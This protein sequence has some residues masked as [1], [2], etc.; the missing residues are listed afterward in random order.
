MIDE[1]YIKF[2]SRWRKTGCLENAEIESLN[3]WRRPLYD[4]GLIGYDE[5]HRIGYGNLSVRA[6]RDGFFIISGS[7]TGHLRQLGAEHYALVERCEIGK[8]RVYSS[9]ACEASSESLTHAAIYGLDSRIGAVV[10]VHC[11]ELWSRLRGTVA[12]TD[13]GVGFGTPVMAQEFVRLWNETDFAR[14]GIAV[15]AGHESGLISFGDDLEQ[16]AVR[17]L[18]SIE[19][20]TPRNFLPGSVRD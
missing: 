20:V 9:G 11:A 8:N 17:I 2:E 14:I 1:G 6:G 5:K 13:A 7:Q 3:R 4:A 16:A 12:T 19:E 15:M 18:S 10:H